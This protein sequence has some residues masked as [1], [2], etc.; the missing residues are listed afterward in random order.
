M[1]DRPFGRSKIT[2]EERNF[3]SSSK[4]TAHIRTFGHSPFLRCGAV[5]SDGSKI[6]YTYRPNGRYFSVNLD[7]RPFRQSKITLVGSN[8]GPSK[9]TIVERNFG[10]SKITVVDRNFGPSKTTIVDRY[11]GPS[12][13][14]VV[15]RNFGP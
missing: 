3:G 8:F 4:W 5:H 9:S 7:Q 12:K 2:V 15:D 13:I 11:F 14:T 10:P 1:D 6:T